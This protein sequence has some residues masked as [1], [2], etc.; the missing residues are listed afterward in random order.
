MGIRLRLGDMLEKFGFDRI[1]KETL[2]SLGE[3][4]QADRARL[5][6]PNQLRQ[7]KR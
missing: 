4:K 3:G 2:S 5:P 1:V 7:A 6:N